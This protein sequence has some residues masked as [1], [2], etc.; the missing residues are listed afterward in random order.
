M[1]ERN[2]VDGL[3]LVRASI[4]HLLASDVAKHRDDLQRRWARV[5]P[6]FVAY[7]ATKAALDHAVRMLALELDPT[8]RINAAGPGRS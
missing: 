7:G 2:V 6:G 1:F 3:R 8:I 4:P 5:G